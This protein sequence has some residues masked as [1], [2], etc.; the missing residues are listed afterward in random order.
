MKDDAGDPASQVQ[1]CPVSAA[2]AKNIPGMRRACQ[3]APGRAC[4]HN[5]VRPLLP[6]R[7]KAGGV[8]MTEVATTTPSN[9]TAAGGSV[10]REPALRLGQRRDRSP[11]P[12]SLLIAAS[13]IH[14]ADFLSHQTVLAV[15]FTMAIVGVL[16]VAQALVGISRRHPRPQPADRAHPVGGDR[17]LAAR[18]RRLGA[19]GGAR[20][21]LVGAAWGCFNALIIVLGK[22]NPII[23]TLAHQLHRRRR[24]CSSSTR[25]PRRR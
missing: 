19:A 8:R 7:A 1:P 5:R 3:A 22:L 6:R 13:G 11:L 16:A 21:H 12:G 20:R 23:V 9:L 18:A 24:A 4:G 15:T 17:R 25:T 2:Q 10:P 14:R